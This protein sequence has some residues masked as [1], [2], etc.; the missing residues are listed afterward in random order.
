MLD[1][2]TKLS[3]WYKSKNKINREDSQFE[4]LVSQ[5]DS[6]QIIKTK[7]YITIL[8]YNIKH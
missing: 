2:N 3:N 5:F 1:L 6:S 8:N 7:E 4:F